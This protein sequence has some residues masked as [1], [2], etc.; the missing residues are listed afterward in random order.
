MWCALTSPRP[1]CCEGFRPRCASEHNLQFGATSE[2]C[3]VVHSAGRLR[4]RGKRR[5][6]FSLGCCSCSSPLL[7]WTLL[8]FLWRGVP[9]ATRGG[10]RRAGALAATHTYFFRFILLKYIFIPPWFVSYF[11]RVFLVSVVRVPCGCT[12]F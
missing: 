2:T 6:A 11:T 1:C 12:F 4:Q 10:A 3:D 5:F 9:V 8:L 7:P